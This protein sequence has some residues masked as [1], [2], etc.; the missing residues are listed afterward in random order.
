V[1]RWSRADARRISGLVGVAE[2]V[3]MHQW[4]FEA[5]SVLFEHY[6]SMMTQHA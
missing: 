3:V 4:I 6:Q 5:Q 1:A 2:E